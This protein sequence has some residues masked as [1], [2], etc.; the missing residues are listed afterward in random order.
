[1]AYVKP[2]RLHQGDVVSVVSPSWGGPFAFPH[3]YEAG[4]AALRELGLSIKEY[5]ST[6]ADPNFLRANPEARARDIEAAFSDPGTSA[7][8][9]SIGG[10]DSIRVLPL[11][12]VSKL[13]SKPKILLGYSDTTTLHVLLNSHGISSMYGPSVMAGL[14]QMK[15]LP[16]AFR[17]HLQTMLFEP[18]SDYEYHAYA[19]YSDGYPDWSAVDNAGMV[20][21]PKSSDGWH[22][23]QGTAVSEGVLFGGCMEVLEMIKGTQFWPSPDFWEDK[24]LFLETSEEKPSLH[25]I[26][27]VLRNYGAMGVLSQIKGLLVGRARD[28]SSDEKKQLESLLISVISSEFGN[29]SLPMITN[30]DFGHTDPQLLLPLGVRARID[31]EKHLFSLTEPWLS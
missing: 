1:M 18:T 2:V 5:P 19:A 21:T 4:L 17:T 10:D 31:S 26:D 27:H 16:P 23:L 15:N 29:R 8:I 24:I 20:T 28:F 11:L 14:S 13:T 22:W 9:A 3:I 12:D 25:Y 30:V 6:R 7:V